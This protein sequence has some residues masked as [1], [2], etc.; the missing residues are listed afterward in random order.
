MRLG[1]AAET[2]ARLL[3][4]LQGTA[5]Q[6]RLPSLTLYLHF[7]SLTLQTLA[8]V[9]L[10]SWAK[11]PGDITTVP[12][13]HG[14]PLRKAAPPPHASRRIGWLYA[15]LLRCPRWL[16]PWLP[17]WLSRCL[18]GCFTGCLATLAGLLAVSM[19]HCLALYIIVLLTDSLP[20]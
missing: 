11:H 12:G 10:R 13:G 5:A 16:P 15:R 18:A 3:G 6:P 20:C 9:R 7:P 4:I 19:P 2:L 8:E 14:L 1:L 17:R